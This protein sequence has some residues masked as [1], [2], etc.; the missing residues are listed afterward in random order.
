MK[1]NVQ[2]ILFKCQLCNKSYITK[3]A[4]LSHNNVHL[5]RFEC[6]QCKKCFNHKRGLKIH[7]VTH[8]GEKMFE[9][10]VCGAK[11]AIKKKCC[12]C[13]YGIHESN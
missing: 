13:T 8:T 11:F 12:Q 3:C 2:D 7:S 10:K 6:N 1:L 4:L 9:C 5:K